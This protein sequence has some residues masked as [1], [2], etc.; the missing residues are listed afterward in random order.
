MRSLLSRL[1][2][3]IHDGLVGNKSP[4]ASVGGDFDYKLKA[5]KFILRL[6]EEANL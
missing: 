2:T 1:V 4:S 3:D 5:A 6:V